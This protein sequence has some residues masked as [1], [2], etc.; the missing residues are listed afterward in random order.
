MIKLVD[1]G[2]T[3]EFPKDS[4]NIK[5]VIEYINEYN[6]RHISV[7]IR[8]R[9]GDVSDNYKSLYSLQFL[10]NIKTPENIIEFDLFSEFEDYSPIYKFVN[11]EK[12]S[13]SV[14]GE[15]IIDISKFVKLKKLQTHKLSPFSNLD[16]CF[17]KM[18]C[19]GN[20]TGHLDCETK[21]LQQMIQ[22]EDLR[23][24]RIYN[25][26]I[27]SICELKK[28]KK[29]W[30]TQCDLENL[31]G[32]QKLQALEFINVGHCNKFADVNGVGELQKLKYL[33]FDTCPKLKDIT[34]VGRSRNLRTLAL[35]NIKIG[36]FSLLENMRSK[37][38]LK[39]LMLENCGNIGSIKFLEHYPSLQAFDCYNT[40]VLDGD[41]K[42]CLR[43][44]SARIT[45]KR[46]Y[47]MKS[48]QLPFGR[49]FFQWF[50]D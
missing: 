50:D 40:N 2:I 44:E 46:H 21:R 45:N 23:L 22:L 48:K 29:L 19:Y 31:C 7:V 36:D 6:V 33:W 4:N 11:L 12:F 39:C 25:F 13:V 18:L 15:N 26:S 10:N 3:V 28:L 8:D 24:F 42:P 27:E 47:N 37:T 14:G 38:S 35:E 41:I 20:V 17:V 49:S 43:L 1:G 9:Q 30:F 16:K 32:I 34:D 5:G